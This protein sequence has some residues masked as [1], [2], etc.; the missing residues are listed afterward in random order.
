MKNSITHH[1]TSFRVTDA[2]GKGMMR[3]KAA[4]YGWMAKKE[5]DRVV[6]KEKGGLF[7][8]CNWASIWSLNAKVRNFA[9]IDSLIQSGSRE[10]QSSFTTRK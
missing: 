3:V 9:F 2:D 1:Q 5:S 6:M 8:R 7:F 4:D 10:Q